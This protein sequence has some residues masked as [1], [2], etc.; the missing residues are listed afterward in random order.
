MK[1]FI[2]LVLS[3]AVPLQSILAGLAAT[4]ALSMAPLPALAAPLGH[5]YCEDGVIDNV[6]LA[7]RLDRAIKADPTGHHNLEKCW[8]NPLD[9]LTGWRDNDTWAR[10]NLTR[11]DQLVSFARDDLIQ[12]E[13]RKG[14]EYW[15]AC[16]RYNA[17]GGHEVIGHCAKRK[18]GENGEKV[19]MNRHNGKIDLQSK[20][21]NPTDVPDEPKPCAYAIFEAQQPQE[22]ALHYD[23]HNDVVN[24]DGCG[25]FRIV[26]TLDKLDAPDAD[27]T[28]LPPECP[29]HPCSFWAYN[30]FLR[31]V[32]PEVGPEIMK[33]TISLKA[34]A[35]AHA[36]IVIRV[37]KT[38]CADRVQCVV[39]ACMEWNDGKIR[40]TSNTT[41]LGD[42][43]Y[44]N[45][46]ARAYHAASD[47]PIELQLQP[48]GLG[49]RDRYLWP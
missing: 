26:P 16:V 42:V 14:V 10:A 34:R 7:K 38:Q 24:S 33:G 46:R 3:L 5:A 8:A 28:P 11:V 13:S 22:V 20:C 43:D 35:Q 44:V 18:I 19:Y 36:Y 21:A 37:S 25:G 27:W 9:F 2:A 40:R 17:N 32:K 4:L 6:E 47:V 39:A 48:R 30:N 29:G 49:P 1:R 12:T 41:G 15:S 31:R 45:D 23:V